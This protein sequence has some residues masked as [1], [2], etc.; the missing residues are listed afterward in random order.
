MPQFYA[1]TGHTG[2]LAYMAPEVHLGQRYNHRADVFSFGIML[3]ETMSH[4]H[5]YIHYLIDSSQYDV[6]HAGIVS[7]SDWNRLG[8]SF[9]A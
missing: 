4:V 3:Y 2:S 1:L 7:R 8:N 6:L 5:P 9:V